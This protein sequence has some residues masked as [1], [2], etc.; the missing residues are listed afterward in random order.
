MNQVANELL[1]S[2]VRGQQSR[3]VSP[4]GWWIDVPMYDDDDL[5]TVECRVEIEEERDHNGTGDSPASYEVWIHEA[6]YNGVD[7][8]LSGAQE[9]IVEAKAI[10]DLA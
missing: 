1:E 10:K 5:I 3:R 6:V 2:I 9:L 8:D 7:Y 4:K